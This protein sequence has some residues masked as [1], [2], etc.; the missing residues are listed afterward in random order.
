MKYKLY[1]ASASVPQL[2]NSGCTSASVYSILPSACCYFTVQMFKQK[3]H[4]AVILC[5]Y[6]NDFQCRLANLWGLVGDLIFVQPIHL[7]YTIIV[8]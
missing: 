2:R 1:I 6:I 8:T 5:S 7:N 4:L 3:E